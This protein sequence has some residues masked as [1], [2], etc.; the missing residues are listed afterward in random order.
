MLG[1][2]TFL[3]V[4]EENAL[5]SLESTKLHDMRTA[6]GLLFYFFVFVCSKPAASPEQQ[7]GGQE[8]GS[9]KNKQE[10]WHHVV[11]AGSTYQMC[12]RGVAERKTE[13]ERARVVGV[14]QLTPCRGRGVR[15]V[16]ARAH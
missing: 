16:C 4:W 14:H 8:H 12:E 10:L 11:S 6:A 3:K 1:V 13:R 5:G 9:Q 2:Y 15:D 7:H